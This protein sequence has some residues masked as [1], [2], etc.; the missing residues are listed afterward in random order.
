MAMLLNKS[1][2]N[3]SYKIIWKRCLSTISISVSTSSS[4]SSSSSSIFSIPSIITSSLNNGKVNLFSLFEHQDEIKTIMPNTTDSVNTLSPMDIIK[5]NV[6]SSMT[7]GSSLSEVE[8]LES[9]IGNVLNIKRTFQ[10]SL[11]RR[12]SKHGFLH[13]IRSKDGIHVLNRRRRKGR[14]N[15]CA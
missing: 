4:S 11:R 5:E 3:N 14:R 12:K 6:G 1:I 9:L 8:S 13:R 2:L 7:E 10:P 15:L